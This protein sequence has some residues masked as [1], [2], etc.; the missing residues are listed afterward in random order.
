MFRS[1]LT[2]GILVLVVLLLIIGPKK[3]PQLGRGLGDGMRE[4]KEGITGE[5]KDEHKQSLSQAQSMPG[6]EQPSPAQAPHAQSAPAPGSS[7][8]RA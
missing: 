2:D 3:L 8:H 4:F 5:N 1:P 6:A 7:E